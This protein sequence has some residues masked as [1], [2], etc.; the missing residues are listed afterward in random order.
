MWATHEACRSAIAVIRPQVTTLADVGRACQRVAHTYG[1]S[2]VTKYR[3]HGIGTEFHCAPFIKHYHD[4]EEQDEEDSLVIQEGMIFTI[5]PMLCQHRNDCTEWESDH[6]T[7]TTLDGGL[8][9]Q[10]EHTV[11]ITKTGAEILTLPL[12]HANIGRDYVEE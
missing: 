10:F 11:L 8:S 1:Y 5:E 2:S 9:C 4:D 3:G 7:V 6:W 12:G